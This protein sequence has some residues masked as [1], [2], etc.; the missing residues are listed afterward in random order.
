MLLKLLYNKNS[1][2]LKWS[3]KYLQIKRYLVWNIKL[4][5]TNPKLFQR[6]TLCINKK[7]NAKRFSINEKR[8]EIIFILKLLSFSLLLQNVKNVKGEI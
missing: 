6:Y 7:K 4:Y 8:F 5:I 3:Q 1:N 2:T